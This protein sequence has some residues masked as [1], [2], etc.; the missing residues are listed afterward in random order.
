MKTH[1]YAFGCNTEGQLGIKHNEGNVFRPVKVESLSGKGIIKMAAS[2]THSTALGSNGVLYT[3]GNNDRNELGREGR[4]FIFLPVL[5]LE[6]HKL[7]S[8]GVGD[9]FNLLFHLRDEHSLLESTTLG[10]LAKQ[11]ESKMIVGRP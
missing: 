9:G 11:T 8:T 2:Q 5:Q 1:V 6:A 3:C 4:R 10:S 7:I